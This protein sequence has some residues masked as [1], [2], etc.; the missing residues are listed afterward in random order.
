VLLGPTIVRFI[1]RST[2]AH[3]A[4]TKGSMGINGCTQ[5]LLPLLLVP[6]PLPHPAAAAAAA[7]ALPAAAASAAAGGGPQA[8]VSAR[9]YLSRLAYTLLWGVMWPPLT[10]AGCEGVAPL[11]PV[12]GDLGEQMGKGG[13]E[14]RGREE[15]AQRHNQG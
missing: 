10:C 1:H 11:R 8:R 7:A 6:L 4:R 13:E 15:G 2:P 12:D 14:G 3:V 5:L 9:V